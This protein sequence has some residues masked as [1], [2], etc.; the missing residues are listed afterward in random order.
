MTAPRLSERLR[1]NRIEAHYCAVRSD[2][3]AAGA[4]KWGVDPYAWC[5][6]GIS[7]SPIEEALW[8]D[9]RAEGAVFYPQFPVVRYFVDFGNPA[10]KVAIEC[11]GK[12]Y[13]GDAEKD[14]LRQRAIEADGWTV[15]RITGADCKRPDRYK[16]D[17]FGVE[18]VSL[19]PARS[20][21]RDIVL[22]HGLDVRKR[23]EP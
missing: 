10:A 6:A 8:S 5:D 13:H 11:D 3:L 2:I 22:R 14:A 15:Y 17:A 23:A 9:I 18:R 7:M 12:S 20:L 16:E 21:I 4:D 19:G 1:W